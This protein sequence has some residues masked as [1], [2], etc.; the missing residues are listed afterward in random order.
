MWLGYLY[1]ISSEI[2]GVLAQRLIAPLAR[3]RLFG[4]ARSL[5]QVL[6]ASLLLE[7][8]IEINLN[9][10]RIE[11]EYAVVLS[12]IASMFEIYTHWTSNI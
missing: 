10:C 6:N 4:G 12:I 1:L 5:H 9:E 11:S 3:L 7:F 8:M 2:G